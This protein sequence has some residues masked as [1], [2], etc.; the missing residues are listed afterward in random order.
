[1][2]MLFFEAQRSGPLPATNQIPWRQNSGMNDTGYNKE[3]LTGGWYEG[4]LIT[5]VSYVSHVLSH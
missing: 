5:V 2:S 4:K 3:N 1:M